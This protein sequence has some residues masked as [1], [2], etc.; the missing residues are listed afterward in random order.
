M[1]QAWISVNSEGYECTS[2]VLESQGSLFRENDFLKGWVG[3]R[4]VDPKGR[5]SR[6]K[7][8]AERG[9]GGKGYPETGNSM[10]SSLEN[11]VGL[12]TAVIL[13]DKRRV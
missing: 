1:R 11:M 8:R 4:W 6:G 9:G 10:Y 12:G 13:Y 3:E 2:S 7:E 5:G